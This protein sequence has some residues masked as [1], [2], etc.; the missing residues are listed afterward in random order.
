MYSI[1]KCLTIGGDAPL[2]NSGNFSF[3]PP[4]VAARSVAARSVAARSVAARSVAVRSVAA[5]S[6]AAC[7]TADWLLV[8]WPLVPSLTVA[9]PFRR[10][11]GDGAGLASEAALRG[12]R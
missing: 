12:R 5:R 7:S 1:G 4:T 8:L 11:D 6:V 10:V 2:F 9:V 3:A